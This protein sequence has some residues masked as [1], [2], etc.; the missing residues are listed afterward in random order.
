MILIVSFTREFE[1]VQSDSFVAFV[2]AMSKKVST[3]VPPDRLKW[4]FKKFER[5]SNPPGMI[6]V[7]DLI[8]ALSEHGEL[9][10]RLTKEQAI[11]LM[12]NVSFL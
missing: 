11:D 1:S 2:K 7:R 9:A 10:K 6:L 8:T 4:A 5:P 12:N 3:T